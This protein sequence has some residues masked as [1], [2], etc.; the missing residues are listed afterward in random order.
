MT[1][2]TVGHLGHGTNRLALTKNLSRMAVIVDWIEGVSVAELRKIVQPLEDQFGTGVYY[3]QRDMT[4]RED[5][6]PRYARRL[7]SQGVSMPVEQYGAL[8]NSS[9]KH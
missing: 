8:K 2:I 9:R 1:H 4:Q 6:D 5:Y 7:L 3:T